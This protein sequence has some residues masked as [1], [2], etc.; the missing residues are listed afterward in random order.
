MKPQALTSVLARV[1]W[2]S[3]LP[4][5]VLAIW[6]ALDT[7]NKRKL[8]TRQAAMDQL[9]NLAT[10]IDHHLDARIKALRLLADSPLGD[11]PDRWHELYA[12][13]QAFY[14]SFGSHVIFADPEGRMLFNT[15]APFG[16]ELPNLPVSQGGPA[17]HIAIATGQPA[18]SDI[19][20]GPVANERLVAIVVPGVREQVVRNLWMVTLPVSEFQARLDNLALAD[21]WVITLADSSG[22]LIAQRA[23]P[24]FDPAHDVDP[25]WRFPSSLRRAPWQ[26]ELAIPR[27]LATAP[28]V[29]FGF[30]LALAVALAALMG[31][32]GGRFIA[33]RINREVANLNADT[34][35]PETSNI[36]EFAAAS[37]RLAAS[38]AQLRASEASHREMFKV[39][40]QP[41]WVYDLETL[42]FLSVNEAAIRHYGYSRAEFLGMTV[43]DIRPPEDVA[44]LL[45]N[46]SRVSEGLDLAGL[47]RHRTKDGRIIEVEISSHTLRFGDRDAELVRITDVTDTRR[48]A[49]EVEAYRHHL[50][51]LVEERTAELKIAREQAESANRAKS[52]F[53]ANMSHEIRTP[54]NA[55]LGL[56]YL[57]RRQASAEQADQLDKVDAA[58]RHLL[59]LIND[60]LDFSKIEANR[61][62]LERIDFRLSKVLEEVK[63][64]VAE[65]AAAKGIE[66][67]VDTG[68]VPDA[69]NG[70]P[71]RLRQALLNYASNAVK[72]SQHGR[73]QLSVTIIEARGNDLMLRFAVQDSGVGIPQDSLDRI[74]KPF[75]QGDRSTTR[76]FGGTGL[77]LVIARGLAELMGGEAGA[78]SEPGTGSTFWF[79][80]QL[81]SS[82][83]TPRVEPRTEKVQSIENGPGV[84]QVLRSRHAGRRI[85]LVEDNPVNREVAIALLENVALDVDVAEDGLQAIGKVQDLAYDL[86]LMDVQMPRMDGLE[87]TREIRKL[88]GREN[89]PIISMTASA[90][91]E[92][93]ENCLAAGMNDF[94]PKPVEPR[95]LY[96]KLLNWLPRSS[97]ASFDG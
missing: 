10:A 44:K 45:D 1:I 76:K 88:R 26:V 73:I 96:A 7:V 89:V 46:I 50:E 77:G 29:R 19:A 69:L 71:T 84:E 39:N 3:L 61:V 35:E 31:L 91:T 51:E 97:P 82:Q 49:R 24:A 68:D 25:E 43:K 22:A 21:G 54:L 17:P 47:W 66:I 4:T 74:F 53:L 27:E 65:E 70:D 59:D 55:V 62:T 40:P 11:H 36:A 72:F 18:V 81:S 57:L 8:E 15:R 42:R 56:T 12:E 14:S 67:D 6:L 85:L 9:A 33:M 80:V 93:R 94:V 75:E 30:T 13:A 60:I 48:M 63:T 2:V 90:F 58:G 38:V 79:T 87:A 5:L 78:T 92:D 52:A 20:F 37:E 83:R 41:M 86:V 32:L 95:V 16:L 23:P 64:L 34:P 28:I